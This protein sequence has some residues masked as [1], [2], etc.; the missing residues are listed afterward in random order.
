MCLKVWLLMS[1]LAMVDC[2]GQLRHLLEKKV[3]PVI[4]FLALIRKK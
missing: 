4:G 1:I 3:G 2:V